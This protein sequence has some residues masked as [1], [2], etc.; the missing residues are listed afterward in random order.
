MPAKGSSHPDGTVRRAAAEAAAPW[1]DFDEVIERML[2][3]FGTGG[4][5]GR[6]SGGEHPPERSRRP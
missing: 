6:G 1:Q 3:L 2:D 5:A 4:P